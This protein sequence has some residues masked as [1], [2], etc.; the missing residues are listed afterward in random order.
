MDVENHTE[1]CCWDLG[2]E[3][4]DCPRCQADG[5]PQWAASYEVNP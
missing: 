3:D 4:I 1:D 5:F 2:S